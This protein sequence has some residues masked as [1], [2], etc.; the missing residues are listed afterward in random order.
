MAGKR[1]LEIDALAMAEQR[2]L[3][4]KER[5]E[6]LAHDLL[7][8]IGQAIHEKEPTT[9]E[10]LVALERAKDEE[11]AKAEYAKRVR[12]Y[13]DEFYAKHQKACVEFCRLLEQEDEEHTH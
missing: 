5:K 6:K 9:Q 12:R 2:K 10:E 3:R 8:K 13:L 1:S 4:E 11:K 7:V